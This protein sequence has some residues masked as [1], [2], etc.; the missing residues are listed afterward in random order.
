MDRIFLAEHTGGRLGERVHVFVPDDPGYGPRLSEGSVW[1]GGVSALTRRRALR[2][3]AA[4]ERL[5]AGG[6]G[7]A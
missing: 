2:A 6:A 1:T 5:E 7:A 4:R 3:T